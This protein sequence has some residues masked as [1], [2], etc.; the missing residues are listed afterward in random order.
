[1]T[2][3]ESQCCDLKP[4]CEMGWLELYW[5]R[6]LFCTEMF[7]AGMKPRYELDWSGLKCDE[8]EVCFALICGEAEVCP[9]MA[10]FGLG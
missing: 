1:M 4:R 9:A 2:G 10:C 6:E 5:S 7:C 3:V 8:A